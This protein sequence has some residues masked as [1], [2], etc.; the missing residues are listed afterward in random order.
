MVV[1]RDKMMMIS[2]MLI[3]SLFR[4]LRKQDRHTGKLLHFLHRWPTIAQYSLASSRENLIGHV[5]AWPAEQVE[6][7]CGRIA[8]ETHQISSHGI[9]K[10]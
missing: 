5:L 1:T 10:V 9:T 8:E 6:R 3:K 2:V 4:L 7:C